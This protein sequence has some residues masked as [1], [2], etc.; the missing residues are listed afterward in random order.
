MGV[1]AM[2]LVIQFLSEGR[3]TVLAAFT[4]R[5]IAVSSIVETWPNGQWN[6]RIYYAENDVV[7]SVQHKYKHDRPITLKAEPYE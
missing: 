3:S 2:Y 4:T 7:V 5:A 1:N 6:G